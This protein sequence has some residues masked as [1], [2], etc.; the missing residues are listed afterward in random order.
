MA[1]R[2][3]NQISVDTYLELKPNLTKREDWVLEAFENI[4]KDACNEDVADYLGVGV[5]ITS[6]RITGLRKKNRLYLLVRVR[7][8]WKKCPVL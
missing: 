1:S 7:T 2:A 5:N 4:G 8:V 3:I 6:G